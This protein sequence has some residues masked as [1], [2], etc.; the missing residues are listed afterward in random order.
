M[1]IGTRYRGDRVRWLQNALRVCLLRQLRS[2]S[3]VLHPG[4]TQ[5][6]G[7]GDYPDI[8]QQ[9][10]KRIQRARNSRGHIRSFSK[11]RL[12]TDQ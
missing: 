5:G 9:D 12:V 4:Y 1:T 8:I 2:E 11:S 7:A 3:W 6:L 10:S